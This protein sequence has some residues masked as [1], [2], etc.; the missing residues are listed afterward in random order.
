MGPLCGG[1]GGGGISKSPKCTSH[2]KQRNFLVVSPIAPA[3]CLVILHSNMA[4]CRAFLMY[5]GGPNVKWCELM[6]R[7]AKSGARAQ[8][9]P[10]PIRLWNSKIPKSRCHQNRRVPCSAH[11]I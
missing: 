1:A 7:H 5:L 10:I 8:V 2:Q 9:R 4:H 6:V 11:A 3:L